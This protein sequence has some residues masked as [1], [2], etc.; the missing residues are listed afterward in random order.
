MFL[1]H[2]FKNKTAAVLKDFSN[3]D[4]ETA[5]KRIRSFSKR[6]SALADSLFEL[7]RISFERYPFDSLRVAEES[8]QLSSNLTRQKWFA[9][10]LFDIGEYEKSYEIISSIPVARLDTKVDKNR[11]AKINAQITAMRHKSLSCMDDGMTASSN[12][13]E[14]SVI[15]MEKQIYRR[16]GTN[17]K[18]AYSLFILARDSYSRY[19]YTGI[20]LAED[21]LKLFYSEEVKSWLHDSMM[22]T[23]RAMQQQA[24]NLASLSD[25]HVHDDAGMANESL[26]DSTYSGEEP[27]T[28]PLSSREPEGRF[29]HKLTNKLA[30][31]CDDDFWSIVSNTADFL[32]ITPNMQSADFFGDNPEIEVL[33]IALSDACLGE[34][35]SGAELIGGRIRKLVIDLIFSAKKN[36][37][38]TAFISFGRD[39]E[40][41][42]FIDYASVCDYIFIENPRL[43]KEYK[44]NCTNSSINILKPFI[45]P[46]NA[47]P[48]N[49]KRNNSTVSRTNDGESGDQS[50]KV[51]RINCDNSNNPYNGNDLR[52]NI[53]KECKQAGYDIADEKNTDSTVKDTCL[54]CV[55][56]PSIKGNR[57]HVKADCS[58]TAN[59]A[60]GLLVLTGYDYLVNSILPGVQI[61][62]YPDE[63]PYL[64]NSCNTEELYHRRIFNIRSV[65]SEHT[66]FDAVRYMLKTMNKNVTDYRAR[67]LVVSQ[68][69][70]TENITAS[71]N[72]QSWNDKKLISAKDLNSSILKEYE[73]ISWFSD[74]YVY[75]EFYLEDMVNA[76]KYTDVSFVTRPVPEDLNQKIVGEHCYTDSYESLEN[77]VFWIKD[78]DV[79][80]IMCG[81]PVSDNGY[82]VDHFNIK[83]STSFN[84]EFNQEIKDSRQ[85]LISVIIP[86]FNNGKH[87]YSKALM[88]LMRSSMYKDMEIILVDDG[89]TDRETILIEDYLA[90]NI[91]NIVL[92]RFNDG[93][94]GSAARPRNKGV[95]L[96]TAEYMVFLD[97]D[98]EMLDDSYAKLY[99]DMTVHGNAVSFGNVI[100]Q[101]G[102]ANKVDYYTKLFNDYGTEDF[103]HGLKDSI[104]KYNFWAVRLHA[105]MI[106]TDFLKNFKHVQITGAVGEDTLIVWQILSSDIHVRVVDCITHVYYTENIASVTNSVSVSYFEKLMK[107]QPH[108][109]EW[110]LAENMMDRF[111]EK[112]FNG[113]M[114]DYVL[115]K[116]KSVCESDVEKSV[117]IVY[118]I[119]NLYIQ[120]YNRRDRIINIFM[121]HCCKKEYLE[122]WQFIR[123]NL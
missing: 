56:A 113:Y 95:E 66:S 89:S 19:P 51:I 25:E 100:I 61:V 42:R 37:V 103:I 80:A 44:E 2:I 47:N 24:D 22:K 52:D 34:G 13:D 57:P 4:F 48:V 6:K 114:S 40:F 28:N 45:N 68:G 21:S 58:V 120:Y 18:I 87:L 55:S 79:K 7:A 26:E 17:R 54:W 31:I 30:V 83:L 32:R 91:S 3:T 72:R 111:M 16:G 10:R 106:R 92:Y 121:L 110:L 84:K 109:I 96:A 108:K 122:A 41:D 81:E 116:L 123:N 60:R 102:N 99:S 29:Y 86:V 75:E 76:F 53:C 20:R 65:M 107:V 23:V 117:R 69:K 15:C 63:T 9:Y 5:E 64:L 74:K 94:S 77:T 105:L 119:F 39:F 43:L 97:P 115:R 88:S 112:K 8:L 90:R 93:G 78:F 1:F 27:E 71:F 85:P 73:V 36:G 50:K 59:M 46:Y 67:V 82:A 33:F 49:L 104:L 35:W 118:E 62:S 38:T 101:K 98:D 11:Y 70:P 14:L 12:N